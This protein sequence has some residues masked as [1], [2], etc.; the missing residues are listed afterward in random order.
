MSTNNN[1]TIDNPTFYH[2]H[3]KECKE[4]PERPNPCVPKN[5]DDCDC[6]HPTG[7]PQPTPKK[8]PFK[9]RKDECCN[10]LIDILTRIPNIDIGKARK[11]KQRPQ[12]KVKTLCD[13]I[14][15][16][17]AILPALSVLWDRHRANEKGRNDFEDKIESIF[18]NI[19]SKNQDAFDT[20]FKGYKD[21]RKTGK[22]DCLF[23]DCLADAAKDGPIEQ[24]WF[25]EIL[26]R[27]GLQFAGQIFFSGSGGVMGPGLSRLWDN[28]VNRGPNGSG[29]TIYQG[30]WP[31]LTAICPDIS[32]YQ[33]FGNKVSFR[34]A[35]GATH[36]WQNYQYAQN[37]QYNVAAGTGKVTASCERQHPPTP[38]PGSFVTACEG[39]F[40]YT[41][42]NDCLRIPAQRAGG[43]IKLRGF[44]FITPTV[45][46]RITL[47]S[48]PSITF[49]QEC[50]VWG[51]HETALKDAAEH[52]IVDERVKDWVDVAIPSA[53]PFQPGAPLPPGIYTVAVIVNNVT[54]V[55]WDSSVP[56]M[57]ITNQLLL[58]I[59][60]DPN[61]KYLLWSEKGY[62]NTET[63]GLGSDEIWWDA[64]VG[65]IVPNSVPVPSSGSSGMVLKTDKKSFPRDPW[66]DMDDGEAS[67]GY[68]QDI[69][70]PEAFELYGVAVIAILGYE[71]DSE[72]AA[73][74]Q[75][76]NF[77]D[78]F[79]HAMKEIAEVAIAGEGLIS[80]IL[81]VAAKAALSVSLIVLA[82]VAVIVLVVVAFWASWAPADLIA[83][84]I[85]A[86]DAFSAWDN[87]DQTKAL[88]PEV[89]LEIGEV[90]VTHR[91]LPKLYKSGDAAATW[92]TEHQYDTPDSEEASYVLEFKLTRS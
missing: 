56:N 17:D 30:P 28:T 78:A 26:L 51:D 80:S 39:G 15:I 79:G 45:K 88:P 65:H 81:S 21:L 11:P 69:F 8:P 63:S 7:T 59:E 83:L 40:D 87:T 13:T 82:V 92:I 41:N 18:D 9:R 36:I 62:C 1:E 31:W 85:F 2:P 4:E 50:T 90:D 42:G 3:E 49:E 86:L 71:V 46:V 57:L 53:H 10:Q 23:N 20:A 75:I 72:A 35:P 19:P 89:R 47:T 77:G 64:F 32:S 29:A 60:P 76:D 37:C 54:N 5:I 66:D 67:G 6:H 70:G 73:R 74:D 84:D 48:N 12:R 16:S 33:E 68:K 14:G 22:G 43:S 55:V 58:R 52:F 27:E 25:A 38:P 44:N 34:P 61:V 91:M 24:K